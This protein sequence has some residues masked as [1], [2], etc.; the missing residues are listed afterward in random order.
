GNPSGGSTLSQQ[1]IKQTLLTNEVSLARKAKELLLAIRLEKFFTKEQILEA[2]LNFSS[3]GRN[4]R[5]ENVA[6]IEASSQGLF[7]KKAADVNIP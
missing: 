1:L 4:A 6:G 7:G 3:F 2:Y 5:G